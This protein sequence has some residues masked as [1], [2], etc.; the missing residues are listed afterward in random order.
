LKK[1][2][3]HGKTLLSDDIAEKAFVCDLVK[4]KGACCVAGDLGAP[5][6]EEELP[7]ID[8]LVDLVKP[9][10]SEEAIAT[11]VKHGA[12]VLDEDGDYSTT[13]I[14]GRECAFVFY[15]ENQVAKCSIEQAWKD[16]KTD[17]R[18]PI[19][20]HLYP[21]RV[22]MTQDYET[23]NYD[24]WSICAPACELG[25]KLKVP[26]YVFLKEALIRKYGEAWYGELCRVIEEE[27]LDNQI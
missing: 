19:S 6:T 16:G 23:L 14:E 26:V 17:F 12:Y 15:D 21:I 8:G 22:G 27:K 10:L 2:I 7:V 25:E 3:I 20:C 5:L 4:C 18:K 13:T 9:Y 11:L 1:V 24:K